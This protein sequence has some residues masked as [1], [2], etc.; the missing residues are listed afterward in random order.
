MVTH[1]VSESIQK[2]F[3]EASRKPSDTGKLPD[4]KLDSDSLRLRLARLERGGYLVARELLF[5]SVSEGKGRPRDTGLYFDTLDY[6]VYGS[7]PSRMV[8]AQRTALDLLDKIA[9]ALNDYFSIGEKP[10]KVNFHE[11]WREK[12]KEPRWRP[13]LAA[14]IERGN[15]ALIA[16]SE[17]AADLSDGSQETSIPGRLSADKRARHAGTH[18]FVVLHDIALGEPRPNSAIEHRM[19]KSFRETAIR[20]VRLS[21][22]ALLYFLEAIAYEERFRRKGDGLVGTMLV[23]HHHKIRGQR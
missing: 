2:A 14:A 5:Q 9:V 10:K 6:A 19:L 23:H 20:T 13:A 1:R 4:T 17:I 11:F 3:L 21:R 18:R 16:L 8:L 12:P 22:A 15:P 7:T